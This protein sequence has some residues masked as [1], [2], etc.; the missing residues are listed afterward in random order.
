[1]GR[2]LLLTCTTTVVLPADPKKSYNI[3][4]GELWHSHRCSWRTCLTQTPKGMPAYW[5]RRSTNSTYDWS[6]VRLRHWKSAEPLS[7][8]RASR[9]SSFARA[10]HTR[11]SQRFWRSWDPLLQ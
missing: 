5:E 3:I 4:G 9:L 11:T 7:R 2:R 8:K 1:M 6:K 10:S